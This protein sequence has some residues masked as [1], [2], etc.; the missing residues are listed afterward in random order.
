MRLSR[1][2]FALTLLAPLAAAC[3]YKQDQPNLVGQDVRVTVIHTADIHSRLFPYKMV[4]GKIDQNYGLALDQGPYGGVGRMSYMIHEQR[5]QAARSIWLDSGDAFQGAPV[6]NV[7][8]GE[9]EYRALT[10]MG[11]DG[12][13]L[14]NHEFDLG[15]QNLYN[16]IVNYARFPLI[17]ANYYFADITD[18]GQPKLAQVITPFQMYDLDGVKVGV[19]GLG[20]TD[21]ILSAFNGGNS[22]GIRPFDNNMTV[23]NYVSLIRPLVDL[24]VLVS[25]LGLDEDEDL[26]P[27]QVP[28]ENTSLP[29]DG[30]D[31]ILGGH[32]HIV[33]NPPKILQTDQYG[34]P[35]VLCHSG[36]F[37]KYV[38]R[39]DLVVHMGTD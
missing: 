29:D 13:A 8:D 2:V 25:H 5:A 32:L 6:F 26:G 34:H 10:Q 19:I 1:Y 18:P 27:D 28:D 9:V 17:A 21:T 14:G 38:G 36:A 20:N 30:V 33:L 24:V 35:T 15:T 3:T 4:P 37:A 12:A 16:Q 31:L 39:L 11:V 23:T 7:F 22:L